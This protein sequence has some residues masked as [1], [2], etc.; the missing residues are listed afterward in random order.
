MQDPYLGKIPRSAWRSP[1]G[2]VQRVPTYR[3]M[4]LLIP[5]DSWLRSWRGAGGFVGVGAIALLGLACL[6]R[7]AGLVCVEHVRHWRR[8]VF[9]RC[10]TVRPCARRRG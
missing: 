7:S 6:R 9:R 8:T 4:Y 3:M 10:L 1:V 5:R 2:R